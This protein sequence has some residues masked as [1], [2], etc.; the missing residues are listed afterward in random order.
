MNLDFSNVIKLILSKELEIKGNETAM[1]D[2]YF[3]ATLE[4]FKRYGYKKVPEF[5]VCLVTLERLK[6]KFY[7]DDDRKYTLQRNLTREEINFLNENEIAYFFGDFE[8]FDKEYIISD[9][10]SMMYILDYDVDKNFL[11]AK[12]LQFS[13]SYSID[14]ETNTNYAS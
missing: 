2:L 8:V 6:R 14:S 12:A 5:I 1:D 4:D 11:Y 3:K 13:F 9:F 7:S 10:S